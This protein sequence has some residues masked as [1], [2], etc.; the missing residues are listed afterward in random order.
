ML[1]VGAVPKT[2]A[3]MVLF[4][5]TCNWKTVIYLNTTGKTTTKAIEITKSLS[6]P[7]VFFV[8]SPSGLISSKISS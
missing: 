1:E 6:N 5:M 7:V 8:P 3:P 2:K 4:F